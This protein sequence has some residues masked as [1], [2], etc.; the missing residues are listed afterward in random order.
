M[1]RFLEQPVG[2]QE[3]AKNKKALHIPSGSNNL[4]GEGAGIFLEHGTG[5]DVSQ[6]VAFEFVKDKVIDVN[7]GIQ[8]P[9]G[10]SAD[11]LQMDALDRAQLDMRR[12]NEIIQM[13]NG[14][15]QQKKNEKLLSEARISLGKKQTKTHH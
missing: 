4:L 6:P 1:S 3:I 5:L 13:L 11:I 8:V 12:A 10:K 14:G 15:A 2:Y 9:E 7:P